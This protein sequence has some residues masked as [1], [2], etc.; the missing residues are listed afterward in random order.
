MVFFARPS[1]NQRREGGRIMAFRGCEICKQPIEPDRAESDPMTRL[2][3]EHA[4]QIAQF[5]GEFMT[6]AREDRTSKKGGL[7]INIGGVTT[8]L[9][10][11]ETALRKLREACEAER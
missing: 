11:N 8:E 2:C 4:R 5:G 9:V 10:R 3:A 6:I 7:K 1:E